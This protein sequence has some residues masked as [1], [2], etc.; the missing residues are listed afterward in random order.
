M[1]LNADIKKVGCHHAQFYFAHPYSS[2]E[3]GTNENTNDLVRQYFPKNQKL[4]KI[5][6][7]RVD[8]AMTLINHRP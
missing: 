3:R 2:C 5:M 1:K 8:R 4:S 6:D 7:S